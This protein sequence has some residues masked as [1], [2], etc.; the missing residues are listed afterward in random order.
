MGF[1][2]ISIHFKGLPHLAPQHP[3]SKMLQNASSI[4]SPGLPAS[5]GWSPA[6]PGLGIGF[7]HVNPCESNQLRFSASPI[8]IYYLYT[9][10]V[11][12]HTH[13]YIYRYTYLVGGFN[14]SEKY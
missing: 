8:S 10:Y 13:I 3:S 11:Y 5:H 14:P 7:L 4:A 12:I 6:A 2:S 9:S 1:P